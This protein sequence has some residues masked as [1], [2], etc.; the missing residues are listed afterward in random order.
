MLGLPMPITDD[1]KLLSRYQQYFRYTSLNL[2]APLHSTIDA[3]NNLSRNRSSLPDLQWSTQLLHVF[4]F[5]H[6]GRK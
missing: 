3:S 4:I 6:L 2:S 1:R 5:P